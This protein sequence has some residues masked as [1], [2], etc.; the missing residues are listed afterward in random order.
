MVDVAGS[1]VGAEMLF[2]ATG[3]ADELLSVLVRLTRAARLGTATARVASPR[4]AAELE[5]DSQSKG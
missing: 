4:R 3:D 2:R 1:R 5:E